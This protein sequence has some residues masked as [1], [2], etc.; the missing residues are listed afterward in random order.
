[1]PGEL[2][3]MI[4][5]ILL[6]PFALGLELLLRPGSPVPDYL[7]YGLWAAMILFCIWSQALWWVLLPI[8]ALIALFVWLD[9]DRSGPREAPPALDGRGMS[10]RTRL[11]FRLGC[12]S[13]LVLP[14][15][16]AS[17][18]ILPAGSLRNVFFPVLLIAMTGMVLFRASFYRSW[19]RDALDRAG[20]A[21]ST[22]SPAASG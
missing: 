1:M 9:R 12:A 15:M 16:I 22:A 3:L 14:V 7:G 17:L 4:A 13:Q 18:F 11:R 10:R 21:P 5:I 6:I 20:A 2:I 8:L 19:R